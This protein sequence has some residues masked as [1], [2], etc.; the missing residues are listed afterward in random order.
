LLGR[1]NFDPREARNPCDRLT[2][3]A[4]GKHLKI[5]SFARF[6][7]SVPIILDRGDIQTVADEF[8]EFLDRR[9][10][11]GAYLGLDTCGGVGSEFEFKR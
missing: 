9:W 3:L 7:P 6:K 8:W 11:E 2:A 10:E 1:G 5:V 4:G